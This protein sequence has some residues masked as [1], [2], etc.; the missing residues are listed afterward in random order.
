MFGWIKRAALRAAGAVAIVFA[1]WMAGK[2]DQRQKTALK[3]AEGY[4]KTRKEIDDV[5]NTIS[6]DPSVLRDWV[7]ERGKR[8]GDM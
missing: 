6:G 2:R 1:A 4:A 5:E 3:A 7:R 8:A